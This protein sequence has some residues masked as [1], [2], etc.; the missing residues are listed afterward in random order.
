MF[1]L[2]RASAMTS[3]EETI[4]DNTSLYMDIC[5]I[6]LIKTRKKI[7]KFYMFVDKRKLNT[8]EAT[9]HMTKVP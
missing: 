6:N 9:D 2:G 7:F 3:L 4:H 1:S 8:E 5:G